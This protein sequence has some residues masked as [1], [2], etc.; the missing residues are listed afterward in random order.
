MGQSGLR[1]RI[2]ERSGGAAASSIQAMIGTSVSSE[3][4]RN[5][6]VFV[7]VF[8]GLARR[9]VVVRIVRKHDLGNPR[10]DVVR[11]GGSNRP[12]TGAMGTGE[13]DPSGTAI[14]AR[15]ERLF[16]TGSPVLDAGATH[17]CEQQERRDRRMARSTSARPLVPSVDRRSRAGS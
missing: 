13:W 5:F 2:R 12:A 14:A 1:V 6:D 15:S 7:V 9:R 4:L 11:A 17:F 10:G 16:W 8:V 3:P